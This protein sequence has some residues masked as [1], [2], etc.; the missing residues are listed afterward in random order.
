[1]RWRG[2]A[3]VLAGYLAIAAGGLVAASAADSSIAVNGNHRIG[4]EMIRSYFHA[5]PDGRLD[6]ARL[7]TALKE[8]YATGLFKDVKISRPGGRV[9]VTVVENPTI[10]R[11]AFEGNKRLKDDDL[12]KDLESKAGGPLSKAFVHDDVIHVLAL[13]RLGGYFDVQVVPKTVGARNGRVDLV[14]EIKE[15]DKL[16]VRQVVIVGNASYSETKLKGVIKTGVTNLFSFALQNDA[17][18]SDRAEN[19]RDLLRKFYRAHGYADAHVGVSASFDAAKAG[20]VVVFKVEE[21]PQYRLG[22]VDIES[23]MKSVDAGTL[24]AALR[25]QAGDVFDADA[26]E[27]TVDE[28]AVELARRGAPF[29]GVIAHSEPVP[30]QRLLNLT[31]VIGEGKRLYVE[32]IDIHGNTRTHDEVIRR[33]FD[34][35][36]GDAYSRAL[37]DRAERRI[38]ALGYFKT[39]KIVMQPGS[40]PD[41]VVLD[42]TVEEDK[43]GSFFISGG[44][45]TTDGMMASISISENNFLGT[46]DIVKTTISYGQYGRGIDLAFTDP[47]FLDQHVAAGIDLFG[48]QTFASP[49]QSYS[50][51]LYGARFLLGTP[52]NENLT[53]GWNY[54]I[55]NQGLSL[56]PAIGTASLPIQQAAQQG[57]YWVSSIGNS[58][59]YSTL[60]NN[61]NPTSGIH[62]QFNNDVAGLG[63]AAKFARNTNDIRYYHEIV[64]DV[65][66][67]V[68]AQSG[69][70]TPWGGQQLPLL[71]GFFG[72]PQLVRGFAPNGFGPRDIT[73]GTTMDN[74]GGNIYWTTS[75]ELQ[76]PMP[77]VT[78]DAQLR[79]ALFSDT[80]SL[81]ATKASSVTSYASSLTPS[82]Q[83]ANSRA[84]RS[85]LGA[86][87][88]WDSMFG[89]IRVDYAY[90][91]AKEPFDVTQ[92][93]SFHAGGF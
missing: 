52:I 70:V 59:T 33:V 13:Y 66:G 26:V 93:F 44:Y 18:D 25:T 82:Q 35:G 41:R 43:T 78:P 32:R 58:V 54:S 56:D 23:S 21:G 38:K 3:V 85:S 47:W 51:S 68:R 48:K 12:K 14:F 11:V 17:Y 40:A 57:Y 81:W 50:S 76:A 92:R 42:V 74:L 34:F 84:V 55:Y 37:V 6:T 71:N 91:V 31:Y 46:G 63:G 62:A 72:G 30:G 64:G 2:T 19:D 69:Y 87:L 20:I 5:G 1:M 22:K 90:P 79:V 61:R 65:V 10:G 49:Y 86:G 67:M 88:V 29:A 80:G 36:E 53:V 4:A 83:I 75:A 7:D 89:P 15:G 73:P 45:S 39:V 24:R 60:D 27:K 9:V 8:L 77:L 16:A 28:L